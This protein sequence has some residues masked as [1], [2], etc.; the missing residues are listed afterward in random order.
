MPSSPSAP[1]RTPVPTPNLSA[2]LGIWGRKGAD[3]AVTND[4]SFI[5][6]WRTYRTCGLAPPPCDQQANNLITD[7]GRATGTLTP[8]TRTTAVGSIAETNDP[9]TIAPGDFLADATDYELLTLRFA[10][11]TMTFCGPK[12]TEVAPPSVVT[13]R[14]C[15]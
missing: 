1:T 10:S 15:G 6:E 4:G 13:T 12:F 9:I 8:V 3:I 2:F 5:L 11:T 14:P 7:G